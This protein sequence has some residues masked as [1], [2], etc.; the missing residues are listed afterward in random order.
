MLGKEEPAAAATRGRSTTQT[1]GTDNNLRGSNT[2][3]SANKNGITPASDSNTETTRNVTSRSGGLPHGKGPGT[4][5]KGSGPGIDQSF[6]STGQKHI[7]SP[8]TDQSS[9]L[10][11]QTRSGVG[12]GHTRRDSRSSRIG[13]N[14]PGY[15]TPLLP[16]LFTPLT[17]FLHLAEADYTENKMTE[18]T[19]ENS[20]NH[21]ADGAGREF[22]PNLTSFHPHI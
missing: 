4:D 18:A 2:N 13:H 22:R 6:G 7:G 12:V 9:G 11:G 1:S 8:G 14:E 20:H 19:T 21:T 15:S 5:G 17:F 3:T 16:R 10:T